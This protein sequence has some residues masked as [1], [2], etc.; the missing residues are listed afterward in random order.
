MDQTVYNITWVMN[1]SVKLDPCNAIWSCTCFWRLWRLNTVFVAAVA[2]WRDY[3]ATL[4]S[5]FLIS[6]CFNKSLDTY[7]DVWPISTPYLNPLHL[8]LKRLHCFVYVTMMLSV[9]CSSIKLNQPV[10][11]A[12]QSQTTA[13]TL[14]LF[15]HLSCFSLN[16]LSESNHLPW[17]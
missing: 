5:Q 1:K 15:C 3:T 10:T 8:A 17:P 12:I 13:T 6:F 16:V 4:H 9:W 7:P 14:P 2:L 11:N